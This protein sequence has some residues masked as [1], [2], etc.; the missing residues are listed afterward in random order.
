MEKLSKSLLFFILTFS[1]FFAVA[2]ASIKT[3]KKANTPVYCELSMLDESSHEDSFRSKNIPEKSLPQRA[4]QNNSTGRK[5]KIA[6]IGCI[7]VGHITPTIDMI[8]AL[9]SKGHDVVFYAPIY[10]QNLIESTGA[11][12]IPY[13]E[14]KQAKITPIDR[15]EIRVNETGLQLMS[16]FGGYTDYIMPWFLENFEKE[17]FD[18]VIYSSLTIW[19]NAVASYFKIPYL[20]LGISVLPAEDNAWNQT[21]FYDEGKE[22]QLEFANRLHNQYNTTAVN[23]IEMFSCSYA[24]KVLMFSS[25]KFLE[26]AS[27]YRFS[28]PEKYFFLN[29]ISSQT[30]KNFISKLKENS[31]IYLSL[32]T[33]FNQRPDIF[34]SIITYFNQ[35]KYELIVSTGMN[36][37]LYQAL[38]SKYNSS[39]IK[40]NLYTNQVRLLKDVAIFITHA[41]LNSIKEAIS[42]TIPTVAIPQGADQFW[43]SKAITD[44]KI[45]ASVEDYEGSLD[46]KFKAAFQEIEQNFETYKENLKNVQKNYFDGPSFDESIMDLENYLLDITDK[47]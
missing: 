19:G 13:P 32:G 4:E 12:F 20:C 36:E 8:R 21:H 1:Y 24:K 41:G 6:I 47:Q 15:K 17:Q 34:E 11:K 39:N 28:E 16:I 37:N 2:D 26:A 22:Q 33:A 27:N 40:I 44:L 45:G 29:S 14:Q 30:S 42:F 35:T 38:T 9:K 43:I 18:A 31:I 10:T 5:L 3:I 46:N 23:L 25:Q 7:A